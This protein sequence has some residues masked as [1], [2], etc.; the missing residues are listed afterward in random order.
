MIRSPEEIEEELTQKLEKDLKEIGLH[1]DNSEFWEKYEIIEIPGLR[2]I[3][4]GIHI[5]KADQEK[6]GLPKEW[7]GS[8]IYATNVKVYE[9]KIKDGYELV[10][11]HPE[12]KIPCLFKPIKPEE[13]S[14][15]WFWSPEKRERRKAKVYKWFLP[16]IEENREFNVKKWDGWII[17]TFAKK[18][19]KDKE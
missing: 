9:N 7:I 15:E 11:L 19:K 10:A 13:E 1:P 3:S 4:D 8:W 16:P 14:N 18:D 6:S 2:D 17:S 12:Y 5:R